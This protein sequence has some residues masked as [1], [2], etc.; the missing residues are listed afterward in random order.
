M[1]HEGLLCEATEDEV[2]FYIF[3]GCV[4]ALEDQQFVLTLQ[5]RL[6]ADE[7]AKE[8]MVQSHREYAKQRW[9]MMTPQM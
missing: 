5:H 1:V 6:D 8:K 9:K 2:A 3:K 7:T 4:S